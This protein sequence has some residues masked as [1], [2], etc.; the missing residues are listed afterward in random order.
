MDI[1]RTH[2]MV[3]VG[4]VLRENPFFVPPDDQG[5]SVAALDGQAGGEGVSA[6]ALSQDV[7]GARLR[8]AVAARRPGFPL[9]TERFLL[10]VAV[11]QAAIAIEGT[12]V[13]SRAQARRAEAEA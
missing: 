2:P 1:M 3:I 12:T 6:V 11:E 10:R 5:L 9:D 8:V 13:L 7:L 4:G